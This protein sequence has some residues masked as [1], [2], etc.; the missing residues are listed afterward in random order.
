MQIS[1]ENHWFTVL[2]FLRQLDDPGPQTAV[3]RRR[4]D[5]LREPSSF[6]YEGERPLGAEEFDDPFRQG[7]L[8]IARATSQAEVRWLNATLKALAHQDLR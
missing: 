7:I 3:L 1:D 8:Q 2:A 6:F 4:L 5:F